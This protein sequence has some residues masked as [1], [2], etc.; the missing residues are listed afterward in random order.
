M[1]FQILWFI[2]WGVLWA[3]YFMLDGFDF[4]TGILYPFLSRDEKDKRVIINTVGPVWDGNEVWL[5]T[6]GGVTFAAFPSAYAVM[7]SY[8]Y[9]PLLILLYSLIIRGVAFEFRGKSDTVKW[10]RT[11][12]AAIFIGSFLPAL[13]FGV[14]FGNIFKGLP[15][16]ALGYHGSFFS[17]LNPY[18]LLT[19]VLFVLLFVYHGSLWLTLKTSGHLNEKSAALSGKLWYGL[20]VT[21][22]AFLVYTY[23]A[24]PLFANFLKHPVWLIVPAVAVLSM[25]DSKLHL[26]KQ[27]Y[28]QS[29]IAS[30]ITVVTI[31]AT[32]VIGLY[33]NLFPSN[34]DTQYSITIFNA[35]SS[36]YTLKIM[37]VVVLVFIPMVIGY[38]IWVYRVFRGRVTAEGVLNDKDAY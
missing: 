12:D 20:L 15:M 1:E 8:L 37:T 21:A 36:L 7:F 23:F 34:I 32:G 16:D 2:L 10:K 4:G 9:T 18:G 5:I 35:S 25:I 22:A 13:L 29:F 11:W 14:A 33:P 19:G 6:A 3:V 26:Y 30:C 24:T 28:F 38:Q 31:I 17:L 27:Q